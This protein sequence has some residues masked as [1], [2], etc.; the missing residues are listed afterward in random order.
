MK[1][2]VLHLPQPRTWNGDKY[3]SQAELIRLYE[4]GTIGASI[5]TCTA[6]MSYPETTYAF[7]NL[8]GEHLAT[9]VL[10]RGA[11][12]QAYGVKLCADPYAKPSQSAFVDH[13]L[14]YGNQ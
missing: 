13:V 4:Q 12:T 9:I 10:T 6:E 14:S 2:T 11:S 7:H 1:N 3:L 8:N 5:E